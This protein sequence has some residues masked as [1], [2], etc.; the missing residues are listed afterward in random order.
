MYGCVVTCQDM[1]EKKDSA[2]VF[3]KVSK[4]QLLDKLFVKTWLKRTILHKVRTNATMSSSTILLYTRAL[5][6]C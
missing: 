5:A 6:P 1:V 4:W 3:D 2:E